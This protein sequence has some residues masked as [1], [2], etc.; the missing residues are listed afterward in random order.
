MENLEL[1]AEEKIEYRTSIDNGYNNANYSDV[2]STQSTVG[3]S[4]QEYQ[5]D[6][7]NNE[8]ATFTSS[9]GV[10]KLPQD[11]K[12]SV[13]S[14]PQVGNEKLDVSYKLPPFAPASR[15]LS[16]DRY[17]LDDELPPLTPA[18]PQLL[19]LSNQADIDPPASE[20]GDP[21]EMSVSEQNRVKQY[22]SGHDEPE[23]V[24]SDDLSG[25]GRFIDL[26]HGGPM[27]TSVQR[28]SVL[29]SLLGSPFDPVVLRPTE[30]F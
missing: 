23:T 6:D 20:I 11:I 8:P 2:W 1:K 25:P 3:S 21:H 28:G 19:W 24:R 18:N 16:P 14:Y 27:P 30:V 17:L 15:R 9:D 29:G 7:N 4:T 12:N 26:S 10:L 22:G 13:L 5:S